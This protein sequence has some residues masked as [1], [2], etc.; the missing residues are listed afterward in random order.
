[1]SSLGF[2]VYAPGTNIGATYTLNGVTY[3]WSGYAWYRTNQGPINSTTITGGTLI[4]G[5]GTQTVIIN[6]G[7][8]T[9]N[10]SGVLTT[11]SL[12]TVLTS[13]TD[14]S[15]LYSTLTQKIVISDTSTF[16][17]VSDRGSTTTNVI[18][19]AN[20]TNSISTVSGAIVVSGGVGI[21]EDVY[22][23]GTIYSEHIQIAHAIFDTSSTIVTTALATLIDSYPVTQFRS[24]KYL[25]QI[26]DNSNSSYQVSELLMLVAN[27]G[28]TWYGTSVSE[29][30][31]TTNAGEMG[32]FSSQVNTGTNP[33]TVELYVTMYETSYKTVVV[34]RTGLTP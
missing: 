8:I 26:D 30:G 9:I 20:T 2:P 1:M 3:T 27:T 11:S 32:V 25:I 21:A 17:T 5:T 22:V 33:P 10:G 18:T 28:S 6:G 34:L 31:I 24:S 23:G 29:Y 7:N 15:I 12:A 4:I 16:Q 13:G 19:F 14:I